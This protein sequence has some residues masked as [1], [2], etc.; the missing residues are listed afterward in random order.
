MLKPKLEVLL[1]KIV[2]FFSIIFI[3]MHNNKKNGI[4]F[5]RIK[6]DKEREN[7][8]Y[9]DEKLATM[10]T[11]KDQIDTNNATLNKTKMLFIEKMTRMDEQMDEDVAHA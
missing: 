7:M 11:H 2:F 6:L 8:K 9:L 3:N 5:L 10:E 4:K 1:R